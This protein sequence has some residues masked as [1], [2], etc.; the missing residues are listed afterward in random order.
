M[1]TK[2]Q[3]GLLIERSAC[4]MDIQESYLMK[5]GFH[6]HISRLFFPHWS[7]IFGDKFRHHRSLQKEY[8]MLLSGFVRCCPPMYIDIDHRQSYMLSPETVLESE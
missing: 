1:S 7:L 2:L 4:L 3:L 6:P 8:T 5:F